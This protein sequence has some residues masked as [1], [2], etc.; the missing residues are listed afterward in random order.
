MLREKL[1]FSFG[2]EAQEGDNKIGVFSRVFFGI[3]KSRKI[4]KA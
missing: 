1:R 4:S 3:N 2:R